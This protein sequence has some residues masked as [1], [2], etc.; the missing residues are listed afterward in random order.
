MIVRMRKLTNDEINRASDPRVETYVPT[1][2]SQSVPPSGGVA[3]SVHLDGEYVMVD[4]GSY[5]LVCAR[6]GVELEPKS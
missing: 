1:S 6:L 4:R 3:R 2:N 5:A